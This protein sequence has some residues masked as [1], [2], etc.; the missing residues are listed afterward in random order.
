[1]K[2]V[3]ICNFLLK[4]LKEKKQKKK[5]K[6]ENDKNKTFLM[7]NNRKMPKS[8]CRHKVTFVTVNSPH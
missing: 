4:Q 8:K 7:K 5:K 6:N 2:I 1:M 3:L